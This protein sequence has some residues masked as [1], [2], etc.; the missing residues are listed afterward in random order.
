MKSAV[1]WERPEAQRQLEQLA[2]RVGAPASDLARMAAGLDRLNAKLLGRDAQ[3]PRPLVRLPARLLRDASPGG[4]LE[5][6]LRCCVERRALEIFADDSDVARQVSLLAAATEAMRVSGALRWPRI[7][8]DDSVPA[9]TRTELAR[10]ARAHSAEIVVSKTDAPTHVVFWDDDVDGAKADQNPQEYLRTLVVDERRRLALVHWWYTPD[11]RDEWIDIERVQGSPENAD[12]NADWSRPLAP[13]VEPWRA[14]TRVC[15][16]FLRDVD[17]HNEWGCELDYELEDDDDDL[18]GKGGRSTNLKKR[19]RE[20]ALAAAG[21]AA[22]DRSIGDVALLPPSRDETVPTSIRAKR[23]VVIATIDVAS[24]D[25][26]QPLVNEGLSLSTSTA[27]R[28][29]DAKPVILPVDAKPIMLP[30]AAHSNNNS[31]NSVVPAAPASLPTQQVPPMHAASAGAPAPSTGDSP[32]KD[33]TKMPT[34]GTQFRRNV[35]DAAGVTPLE[36]A[37][38]PEWF[39]GDS[40]KSPDHY[41][42]AR[43]WMIAQSNSRPQNLLTATFCRQ[44]LGLD[45]CATIRLFHF[46]DA[47]GLVNSQVPPSARRVPKPRP[48]PPPFFVK[49]RDDSKTW[50]PEE[51]KALVAAAKDIRDDWNA[52]ARAVNAVSGGSFD[53]SDCASRFV[54]LP[55]R[56]PLGELGE[57]DEGASSAPLPTS[58]VNGDIDVA[59]AREALDALVEAR[60]SRVEQRLRDLARAEVALDAE[61][62]A[63]ARERARLRSEWADLSANFD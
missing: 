37:C 1:D 39:C 50:S 23:D 10:I 60:I 5:A 53:A 30:A 42:E 32:S 15:C 62:I 7:A 52:V 61:R 29:V 8:W 11:S 40:A 3:R 54:E 55:L 26:K 59:A 25:G 38:C 19:K 34:G 20:Q 16:R 6:A 31:N 35:F 17:A 28:L 36:R 56:D 58:N 22:N 2:S 51:I 46:V 27:P 63:S 48:K 12:L 44:R 4:G 33:E 43:N 18:L 9:A 13:R 14:R 57:L 21:R 49:D 24:S 45:A 47:W 41:I